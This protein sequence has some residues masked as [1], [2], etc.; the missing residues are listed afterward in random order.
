[1]NIRRGF[2]IVAILIGVVIIGRLIG[3]GITDDD[4]GI[5]MVLLYV[6]AL[7]ALVVFGIRKT[8]TQIKADKGE[9]Q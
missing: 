9:Q 8:L 7:C 4:V 2:C 5:T 3:N 1:M 6:A